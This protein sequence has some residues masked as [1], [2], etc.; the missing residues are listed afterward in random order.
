MLLLKKNRLLGLL[1]LLVVGLIL[2]V[3]IVNVI[4]QK[5]KI[6]EELTIMNQQDE[7]DAN[8]YAMRA[9]CEKKRSHLGRW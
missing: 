2:V 8:K 7:I 4:S 5:E 9:I 1:V 3:V 6:R